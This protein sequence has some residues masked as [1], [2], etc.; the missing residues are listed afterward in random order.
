MMAV[1]STAGATGTSIVSA[2][3]SDVSD[4]LTSGSAGTAAEI[5]GDEPGEAA[6]GWATLAAVCFTTISNDS[7]PTET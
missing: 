4:E 7:L 6:T 2:T 5:L 1:S 3:L